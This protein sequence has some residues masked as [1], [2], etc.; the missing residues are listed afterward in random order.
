MQ[1][2]QKMVNFE[3]KFFH[4]GIWKK[5]LCTTKTVSYIHL[6]KFC[7]YNNRNHYMNNMM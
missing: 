4:R 3:P 5:P 6:L 7:L 1:Q 2:A